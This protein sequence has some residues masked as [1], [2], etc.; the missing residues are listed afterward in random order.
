MPS[1]ERPRNNNQISQ[2]PGVSTFVTGHN[3]DGKSIVQEKRSGEW[4]AFGEEM[5]FNQI[6]TTKFPADLNNG[7]DIKEHDEAVK[8][9]K[10]GLVKP[11]GVVCRQ[12]G[13]AL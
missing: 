13:E 8:S 11:G 12:V 2:L 10:L 1:T 5:A 9:G 4:V 7:K 6:Y 3:S